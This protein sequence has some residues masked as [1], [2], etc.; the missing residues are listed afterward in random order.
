MIRKLCAVQPVVLAAAALLVGCGSSSS[1]AKTGGSTSSTST[2]TT[3]AGNL[4]ARD[5][6]RCKHGVSVLPA[7]SQA[8]K[9]RLEA[10]CE[11]AA[12]GDRAAARTAA[13]EACE[14]IIKASPLP[15]GRA[16]DR[17]LAGCK[18]AEKH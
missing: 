12:S 9:S 6:K 3:A 2:P 10:I 17:A 16:R 5:V 4:S 8:T 18:D 15:A 13:R 1:T 7:L 14:E 11:K